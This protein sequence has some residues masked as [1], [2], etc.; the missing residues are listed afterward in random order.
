MIAFLVV[1]TGLA[2][3]FLKPVPS[4]PQRTFHLRGEI[5]EFRDLFDLNAAAISPDGTLIAYR[6]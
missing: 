6:P 4:P 3:W 5:N 2:G 1:V